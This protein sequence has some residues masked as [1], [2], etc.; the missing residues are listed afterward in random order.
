MAEIAGAIE[1]LEIFRSARLSGEIWEFHVHWSTPD[2]GKCT[3]KSFPRDHIRYALSPTL[4]RIG[5]SEQS[6]TGDPADSMEVKA[7]VNLQRPDFWGLNDENLQVTALL[8]LPG[9]RVAIPIP[10][11]DQEPDHLLRNFNG[12]ILDRKDDE[13]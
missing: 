4:A 7:I 3:V 10:I 1:S 12:R 9:G 11:Q 8:T 2:G 5:L 6:L 13:D